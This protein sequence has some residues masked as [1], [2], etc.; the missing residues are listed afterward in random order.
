M[1]VS[2]ETPSGH[3]GGSPEATEVFQPT[4]HAHGPR[5][6]ERINSSSQKVLEPYSIPQQLYHFTFPLTVHKGSSFSTSSSALVIFGLFDSSH[7][8]G[9]EVGCHSGFDLHFPKD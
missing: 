8:D 3:G 2:V 4:T 1:Q 9:C 6:E 5:N 7:L